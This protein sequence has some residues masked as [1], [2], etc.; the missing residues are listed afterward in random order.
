MVDV[1]DLDLLREQSDYYRNQIGS[2]V[3]AIGAVINDKPNLIVAVTPD[4]VE[5]GWDAR[6]IVSAAAQ[7]MGGG[8]GGKPTLAQAGGRDAASL[9]RALEF[10][11]KFLEAKRKTG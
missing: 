6:Q 11:S 7:A 4:L 1:P 5:Q 8:G 3:V 2:G 10:V 9:P